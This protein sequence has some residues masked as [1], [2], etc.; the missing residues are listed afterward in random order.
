[1]SAMQSTVLKYL[2]ELAPDSKARLT[3]HFAEEVEEMSVLTARAM[4]ALQNYHRVNPQHDESNPKQVAFGLMTKGTNTL[5]AA[6]E[7]SLCGYLWEPL[8][9]LRS[10]LE[11]FAT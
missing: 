6:F 11:G 10:A 5:M 1:M 9:L 4:E 2:R 7:L 3:A 8:I